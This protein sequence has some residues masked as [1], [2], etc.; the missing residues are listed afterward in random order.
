MGSSAV[1]HLGEARWA[2]HRCQPGGAG[3]FPALGLFDFV[4]RRLRAA[5]KRVTPHVRE[6]AG[7][8]DDD[9]DGRFPDDSPVE[10]RYPRDNRE[11]R[12]DW[13]GLPWLPAFT[14]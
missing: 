12:D 2:V 14:V 6:R 3:E 7:D 13:S 11:E 1:L 8:M 9:N 10:V 4:E 5:C